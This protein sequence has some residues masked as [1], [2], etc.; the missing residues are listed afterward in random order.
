MNEIVVSIIV[1]VFNAEKHLEKCLNSLINQTLTNIEII[2]IN[3]A[4][5]DNS[6]FILDSYQKKYSTLKVIDLPKNRKQ[7]GARN[8]GLD[9]ARGEYLGFVDSDDWVEHT[10]YEQLYNKTKHFKFDAVDSDYYY[11]TNTGNN[12]AISIDN[13]NI[14]NNVLIDP[15]NNFGRLVTKIIKNEIFNGDD[16]L[17][18]PEDI[19]YE[20]NYLQPFLA[21]SVKSICKVNSCFYYY[22]QNVESTTK[23][24]NDVR[25]FDRLISAELM[26][27]D[28]V[29]NIKYTE[30]KEEFL[31]RFFYLYA[32]N[33]VRMI[34]DNFSYTPKNEIERIK[35]FLD[36]NNVKKAKF[37]VEMTNKNKFIYYLACYKPYIYRVIVK[38]MKKVKTYVK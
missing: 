30:F 22:Y 2:C 24:K 14:V 27:Y 1:P 21:L 34:P 5:T 25:F 9:I 13:T 19:F 38:I 8:V 3:D 4:S 29:E 18:F 10:M 26:Y 20:D 7:G 28:F 17:R 36:K 31:K 23:I 15:I 35:I 37:Y 16:K 6:L 12:K 11:S 32:Y 33:T